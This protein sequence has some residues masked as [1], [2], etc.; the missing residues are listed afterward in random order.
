[1]PG[2]YVGVVVVAGLQYLR[3]RERGLLLVV[4][5]FALLAAGRIRDLSEGWVRTWDMA[6]AA[7]GLLL[8]FSLAPRAR[9]P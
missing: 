2:L 4:A 3:G 7:A 9:Q 1:V 5:L 8:V 6:A